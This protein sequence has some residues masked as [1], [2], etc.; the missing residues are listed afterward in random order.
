MTYIMDFEPFIPEDINYDEL[1]KLETKIK[2]KES[3]SLKDANYFLDHLNYMARELI[4]PDMNNFRN[5]CDLAQSILYYY[6]KSL[7]CAVVPVQTQRA[8]T[9][10]IV[11]HNFLVVEIIIDGVP[12]V[13]LV[14]PTY[15]Q[16]FDEDRCQMSNFYISPLAPDKILI[17]PDPGFFIRESQKEMAKYLVDHGYS[18]L[19]NEVARMYGDSFFNTKVG[20]SLSNWQ[21]QTMSGNIYI[22]A[23]MKGDFPLSRTEESLR[24]DGMLLNLGVKELSQR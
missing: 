7:G 13:F 6:F 3:L 24:Q 4:N 2:D 20:V 11:G 21:F 12:T 22:S 16:F 19:T 17:T 1:N 14:D 8:I 10:D 5:K 9:H 18:L 23:F 15:I